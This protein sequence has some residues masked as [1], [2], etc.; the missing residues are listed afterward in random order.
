MNWYTCIRNKCVTIKFLFCC[1]SDITYTEDSFVEGKVC[2]CGV[3]LYFFFEYHWLCNF[4]NS[5]FCHI[6][7][8]K[9]RIQCTVKI[10]WT[11]LKVQELIWKT[12]IHSCMCNI[13]C[14]NMGTRIVAFIHWGQ[15]NSSEVKMYLKP[16]RKYL[17]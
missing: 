14:V 7:S 12:L 5:F 1:L 15:Q 16:Q 9:N 13:I 17:F 11:V 3:I 6:K 2:V 8:A 4:K 10:L